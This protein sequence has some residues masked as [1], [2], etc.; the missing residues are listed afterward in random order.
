MILNALQ[1][2]RVNYQAVAT[3]KDLDLRSLT[4]TLANGV[5][6]QPG[7][8]P[9]RIN[10][11]DALFIAVDRDAILA[12]SDSVLDPTPVNFPGP[13]CRVSLDGC[14]YRVVLPVAIDVPQGIV[15]DVPQGVLRV[16]LERGFVGVDATVAG[17]D[18][19]FVNT[20]LEGALRVFQCAQAAQLISVLGA[21]TPPERAL[22]VVGDMNSS[23]DDQPVTGALPLDPPCSPAAVVPPYMQFVEAGYTDTWTLRPGADPGFTCCQAPDLTNK[24]STLDKQID[25]IVSFDMLRKVKQP[26]VVGDN[27]SDKTPP[28]GH[29]LWPSDHGGVAIGLEF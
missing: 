26:R 25:L 6:V 24:H 29:G 17:K 23:P 9:F 1:N 4:I 16:N 19:R 10:G 3:V 7:G 5:V 22:V 13:V 12:R 20:H 18:Y 21:V 15:D 14:N 2:L 11:V 8:L 28:P 27:V